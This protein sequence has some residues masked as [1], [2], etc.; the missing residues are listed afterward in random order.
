MTAPL[1]GDA[2]LTLP[3]RHVLP[4]GLR[5]LT[6]PL[7][8]TH[9]SAIS[10]LIR[11]GSRF[12]PEHLP[13]IAHFHEHMLHRGT[14]THPSAHALAL[15]F[16]TLG[17]ELSAATYVDHTLLSCIAPP[18]NLTRVLSLLGEV[19]SE[20]AFTNIEL[21]RG[22]VHEEILESL[23]EEGEPIDGSEL[24]QGL[25]F[26]G[27]GL[28]RPIAGTLAALDRFDVPTLSDFHTATYRA[29]GMVLAVS[30]PIDP[31]A[32]LDTAAEAFARL[33]SGTAA[34]T[35]Q[36]PAPLAGPVFRHVRDTGSQVALRLAFRAPAEQD[37]GEPAAELLLR[38][39][40][41][42]MSTRLY[43]EVCDER[44]LAYDVSATYEAFADAGVLALAADAAPA[45]AERVL[46]TLFDVVRA[47]R[48]Q[49]PSE[50]EI[51][52][53]KRRLSWQL[54]AIVDDPLELSAF[55]GL[56]ELTGIART[57]EERRAK[58]VNVSRNE[59]HDVARAVFR[60]EQ[61]ALALVGPLGTKRLKALER[62]VRD[63]V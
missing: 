15:A 16:E 40:D 29:G 9:R 31:R 10:L 60:P 1:P 23:S 25:V 62:S 4:S 21:E 50:G 54:G 52:K 14:K 53:V 18:E 42:G 24:L 6:A 55:L 47:L 59:V 22:I 45:S 56:G 43:H 34:A 5:V 33:P 13:G 2:E 36:T 38:T 28:G 19:V 30:G 26:P 63:F 39:I 41:D 58:L 32:V 11:C 57:P 37:P 51:D 7:P 27:H 61:L 49:G 8:H 46:E 44:G 20:P 17:S 35:L 48:E 3:S 12:E